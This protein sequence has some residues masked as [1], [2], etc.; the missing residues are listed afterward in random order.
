MVQAI[1]VIFASVQSLL[2][3]KLEVLSRAEVVAGV[4]LPGLGGT[5]GLTAEDVVARGTVHSVHALL[6][7]PEKLENDEQ[8][9]KT[10]MGHRGEG[11]EPWECRAS[12][13]S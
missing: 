5:E 9:K 8:I 6:F 13:G 4:D 7:S 1:P 10:C 3:R 2:Q 12:A 11:G